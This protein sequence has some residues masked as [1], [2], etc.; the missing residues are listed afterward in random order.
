MTI[1]EW[2]A[3]LLRMERPGT[4]PQKI[5]SSSWRKQ[6]DLQ[7]LNSNASQSLLANVRNH[8]VENDNFYT[9][10]AGKSS[11][12]CTQYVSHLIESDLQSSGLVAKSSVFRTGKI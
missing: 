11:T 1:C 12:I 2:L 6:S 9:S 5:S 7:M 3:W 8:D 10:F 4:K